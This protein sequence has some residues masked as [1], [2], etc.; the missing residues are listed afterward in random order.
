MT[1]HTSPT[2]FTVIIRD[3]KSWTTTVTANDAIEAEELA[4]DLMN[5]PKKRDADDH[6]ELDEDTTV[7]VEE[8][9]CDGGDA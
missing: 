5:D 4:W 3:I 9:R 2:R 8:L 6:F 7:Q 1:D